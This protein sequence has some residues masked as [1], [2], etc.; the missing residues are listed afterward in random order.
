VL[1]AEGVSRHHAR[2]QATAL[3]W[4]V[5]DL[6][7]INGTFLNGR[8]LRADDPSPVP[9]GSQ[10]E[11]GP[12][13]LTLQGPD[14]AVT[15]LTPEQ[16][17]TPTGQTA[18][19]EQETR[20]S[21][22]D[23]P[24]A[25]FLPNDTI[26]VEP[27]QQVEINVEVVNHSSIDDRVSLRIQGLPPSWIA[28][29]GQFV[30]LPAGETTQLT[31]ALRPPRHRSTPLGRQRFRLELVSQRHPD[32]ELG[33][34]ATLI[35][36]AFVAFEAEL[37][38]DQLTLPGTVL[39]SIHNTGNATADFSVVAQDREGMLQFEGERGR[40]R[41]EP[42]QI[43]K[44][45]LAVMGQRSGL[46]GSRELFPF[47]VEVTSSAGERQVLTGEAQ[48]SAVLPSGLLYALIFLIT[49]A[50]VIG[51]LAILYYQNLLFPGVTATPSPDPL[52]AA[53]T[54]TA[55]AET[56]TSVAA[57]LTAAPTVVIGPASV[58][59]STVLNTAP[60][61]L[62][63]GGVGFVDG[64]VVVLPAYGA[65]ET[66]FVSSN[67]L[68]ARLPA[69][70]PPG[71][72]DITVVN[73]DATSY[74]LVGA[75]TILEPTPTPTLIPTDTPVLP[76]PTVPPTDTPLPTAIPTDTPVPTLTLTPTEV[77]T[78]TPTPTDTPLPNPQLVCLSVPPSID[79]VFNP[80]EW[81]DDSL[82]QF[83]PE[84]DPSRLVQAFFARDSDRLYLVFL[85]NDS[86]TDSGD[87]LRVFFDTTGNRED[88]DATDRFFQVERDGTAVVQAGIGSNTDG[89]NWNPS[90][91]SDNWTAE[92]GEPVGDQWVVE[93]EI[94]VAAEMG[95]L[96]NPFG[97]MAQVLYPA[98][99]ATWPEGANPNDASTW[100]ATNNAV[101]P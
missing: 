78:V 60:T 4:E 33:A 99:L 84:G 65:L 29:P 72:Y 27:G 101:C 80:V 30:N 9:P 81:P 95:A 1:P 40:I 75:L 97:L 66:T 71:I 50:C 14:I 96:A 69:N 37:E 32:V 25:L 53:A 87:L 77:P 36:G 20:S 49:F 58:Q 91:S 92:V 15:K 45:E 98:E 19:A 94:D 13:E 31:V 56:A 85:I 73:P 88:P 79:G 16:E 83:Q 11:I 34:N 61:E 76:S 74:S 64:S 59:P 82:F 42:G 5:I 38:P 52:A 46:F 44:V 68:R 47:E 48:S 23:D 8:R 24:L 57:T 21:G 70:V 7:G 17:R 90:Y 12:Y 55:A 28:T 3:G 43:A 51:G 35:I 6:G 39:V 86:T 63:I 26:S 18:A 62:I 100:Q 41:L 93:M 89:R 2:L 54:E 67:L 10:L 22:E